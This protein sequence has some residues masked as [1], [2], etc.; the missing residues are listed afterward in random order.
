PRTGLAPLLADVPDA[1]RQAVLGR[2]FLALV[3]QDPD[4]LRRAA[5][6]LHGMLD[7]ASMQSLASLFAAQAARDEAES[8]ELMAPPARLAP[9][10]APGARRPSLGE[11]LKDALSPLK[12]QD[13]SHSALSGVTL[14]G[15]TLVSVNLSASQFSAV[16]LRRVRLSACAMQGSQFEGCT[17]QACTFAGVDLCNTFF[18]NCRFEGCAFERCDAARL[19]LSS[20]VLAGCSVAESCLAGAHLTKARLD[21]LAVRSSAFCGLRAQESALTQCSFTRCDLSG[22]VLERSALRGSEFVDSTLALLRLRQC[23]VLGVNLTRCSLPGLGMSGG[24]T[25]NPHLF[26]ARGATLAAMLA[27]L[28]GPD[29]ALTDLPQA[30]RSESGAA[31]VAACVGRHVRVDEAR[32]TLA[33][34]RGQNQRRI[35]L[36]LQ[37]LTEPQGVFLRLLPQILITD[38]FEKA[39]GLKGVPACSLGGAEVRVDAALLEKFFPG[40]TPSPSAAPV[41]GP[42]LGIEALYA[43]GS[44]GSVAQ[45]PS[46]DI[47]CWV[48]HGEPEGLPQEVREGLRRKLAALELWADEQFGLEVHFFAMTLDEVRTNSFGMSDKESSGSAQAAL[49]KEEF[50]RTAL[51]LAGRDLLWW[52]APPGADAA[53]AQSLLADIS[54]LDPR[55]A[56]ELVDLG[57]PEPIPASEYFGACL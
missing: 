23:E 18:Q 19:R 42:V 3:R 47:D 14:E 51:R 4:F 15:S 36:A 21:R 11:A 50:Y 54:A 24:H 26:A 13:Y 5:K 41:S 39:Q 27:M 37:R 20:C 53:T 49:L 10:K 22:S 44:L 16:S 33:A 8:A 9:G 29:S 1:E 46:S 57:Q 31:F 32:R 2:M 52:T 35:E 30:L 40:Q 25:D 43:I 56:A 38:V 12:D 55:L 7:T 28:D 6:A 45:K 17:F 34:M 48:C